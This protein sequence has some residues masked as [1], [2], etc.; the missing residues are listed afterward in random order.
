MVFIAPPA[1][2][3]G[4][5]SKM[6]C[7]AYGVPH[8]SVGDIC[9]EAASTSDTMGNYIKLQMRLGKLI[10]DEMMLD[11]LKER[12]RKNDCQNGYVLDGF[13]RNLSQAQA[14]DALLEETGKKVEKVILLDLD[15]DTAHK[16]ITGR[17]SCPK[18][19]HVY[20]DQFESLKPENDKVC[21]F[22]KKELIKRKDD[23]EEAFK[24]RYETYLEETKPLI[25]YYE[26]K[27]IVSKVDSTKDAYLIF[28]EIKKLLGDPHDR[29]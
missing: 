16:R 10:D 27:N 25:E 9:R 3:K 1:A 19:G 28:A 17:L 13:P 26:N 22:C 24:V 21:D 2:G 8:I 4:T 29:Y 5:Q 7:E 15:Y 12:L 23:N 6:I 11:L 18:C 14:Y 20:N